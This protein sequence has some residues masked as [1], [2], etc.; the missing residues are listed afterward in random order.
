ML[1]KESKSFWINLSNAS[2]RE[3]FGR[4]GLVAWSNIIISG[5]TVSVERTCSMA[6]SV[7]AESPESSNGRWIMAAP[8]SEDIEAISSSLVET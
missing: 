4:K 7:V 1:S 8:E 3:F 6:D 5:F 2:F